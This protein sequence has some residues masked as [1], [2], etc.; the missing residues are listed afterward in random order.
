[1]RAQSRE[2]V[3]YG[4]CAPLPEAGTEP[5][6]AAAQ[7]LRAWQGPL[8]GLAV[9]DAIRQVQALDV[10]RA[11]AARWA[12]ECA[13]LDL[14]SRLAA[15]PLRDWIL[16]PSDLPPG[17]RVPVNAALGAVMDLSRAGLREPLATGFRVLKVKLG[18]APPDEELRHLAFLAAG[19][20]P[21]VGLRLDAN[22][23][24]DPTTAKGVIEALGGLPVESLEEPL[25]R[26][27]PA[28]LARL[29]A[30]APF[31]LAVD[32]SL[33][34]LVA[35]PMHEP[36]PVRRA[37]I[38]P[39]VIGGLSATLSL[40]ARLGQ[41]GVEVVLTG[42]VDGAA[43]LWA[44]AQVAAAVASPFAQGLATWDWLA[45]DLGP[46]PV[47]KAGVIELPQTPGSGFSPY[48]ETPADG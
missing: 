25:T 18:C 43:G 36:F 3:G 14:G 38:K 9:N 17:N 37:V 26:V 31:P 11:P 24:W 12:L 20:P 19:L 34:R 42:M 8:S 13:L 27:D 47:P 30:I 28:E 1:M 29:Q 15:V 5:P 7:A 40:A 6:A 10:R 39:A 45:E 4:D 44:T 22:G 41:A 2:V 16:G 48:R 33:P 35:G 23:A 46:P 32:E 21:G